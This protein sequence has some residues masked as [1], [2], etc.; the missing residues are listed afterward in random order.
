MDSRAA[1]N[2]NSKMILSGLDNRAGSHSLAEKNSPGIPETTREARRS[3]YAINKLGF[4]G[5]LLFPERFDG[6]RRAAKCQELAASSEGRFLE[7]V[8]M[9][10]IS[11]VMDVRSPLRKLNAHSIYSDI[12]DA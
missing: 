4:A 5:L 1:D 3:R 12:E 8:N 9:V 2:T 10:A 7:R 11:E 6:D